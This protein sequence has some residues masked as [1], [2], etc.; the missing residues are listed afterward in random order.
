MSNLISAENQFPEPVRILASP[1]NDEKEGTQGDSEVTILSWTSRQRIVRALKLLLG[2]WALMVAAVFVPILHFILV[3]LLLVGGP[4]AAY[5]S[6]RQKE[7]IPATN[8]L[9]PGCKQ[10]VQLA[11]S[12]VL[13]PLHLRCGN[14][15]R[16]LRVE[17]RRNHFS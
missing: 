4:V 10:I 11:A 5:L 17:K 15:G 8:L 1:I 12:N 3:P 16:F 6:Y 13:W 2:L 14:C 7:E 9:C